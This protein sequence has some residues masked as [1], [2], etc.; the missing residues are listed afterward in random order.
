MDA[1]VGRALASAPGGRGPGGAR[2]RRPSRSA[3]R[4]HAGVRPRSP[5]A[6]LPGPARSR[7]GRRRPPDRVR[8]SLSRPARLRRALLAEDMAVRDRAA[9]VDG[10]DEDRI[11]L[12]APL[13]ARRAAA[14][15]GGR[16]AARR[17]RAGGQ[18]R[19]AR[20]GGGAGR[21]VG[22]QPDRGAPAL[23]G[24]DDVRGDRGGVPREAGHRAGAG[25]AS[26]AAAARRAVG[27]RAMSDADLERGFE[28]LGDGSGPPEDWQA[29]VLTQI[30]AAPPR[31][32]PWPLVLAG[33][34]LVAATAAMTLFFVLRAPDKAPAHPAPAATE[35]A[36]ALFER[37]EGAVYGLARTKDR[38][39]QQLLNAHT[40]A[41]RA[42][43][44]KALEDARRELEQVQRQLNKLPVRLD[45]LDRKIR[46]KCDPNDPLCGVE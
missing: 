42:L 27:R 11:A 20:A 45:K 40:E 17:R 26:A 30:A 7:P 38:A 28:Q 24:G 36:E 14:G 37:L 46:V 33:A 16:A 29:K 21:T 44:E 6:L 41:E 23:L 9:P 43:A 12:A 35:R 5:P 25:G 13:R 22:R 4:P 34:S 31:R 2:A 32:A 8:A 1:L 39:Y 18:R 15:G 3:D 19:G 10:R